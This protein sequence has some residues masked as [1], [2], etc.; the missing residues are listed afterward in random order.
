MREKGKEM[1]K[2]ID[3]YHS[4]IIHIQ[5]NPSITDTIAWDQQTCPFNGGVLC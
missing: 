5:W 2:I 4:A 1:I 3:A